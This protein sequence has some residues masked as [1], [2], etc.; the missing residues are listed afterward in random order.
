[1][2]LN[3]AILR[4][5]LAMAERHIATGTRMVTRQ[6]QLISKLEAGRNDIKEAVT[7]LTRVS[8]TRIHRNRRPC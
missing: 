7:L 1:M 6:R 5:R 2:T 3:L 8:V 4:D